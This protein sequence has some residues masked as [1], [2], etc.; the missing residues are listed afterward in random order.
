[1]S[2]SAEKV[3]LVTGGGRRVGRALALALAK[4]GYRVAVHYNASAGPAKKV[5]E[6]VASAGLPPAALFGADLRDAAAAQ[7]LPES[8]VKQLGRLDVLVN[9]AAVMLKQPFG[10]VTPA[11]WDDVLNLNLRACFFTA[12]GAAPALKSAKGSILNIVD[13]SAFSV[14]PSYLPHGVSKAGLD[15]LTRSLAR[16][17]APD[18]RVNA[19]AP[20]AVLLPDG[21]TEADADSAIARTP[22]GRLGSPDDVVSA[23]RYL[24][25]APYVTGV[26]IPVDGGQRLR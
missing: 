24:L 23:M 25:S 22:L 4:D 21:S 15:H 6:E 10:A 20:G 9:S 2:P 13:L 7:A 12:Q 17:L 26:T 1:V 11:M 5:A 16:V 14:W 18:V 8:V 19:I 3:A